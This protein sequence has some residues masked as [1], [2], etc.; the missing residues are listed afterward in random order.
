MNELLVGFGQTI[1]NPVAPKCAGCLNQTI[2]PAAFKGSPQKGRV[3]KESGSVKKEAKEE[4]KLVKNEKSYTPTEE[5]F[6]QPKQK[7]TRKSVK[8]LKY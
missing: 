8:N 3:K 5:D 6:E 2:C 7:R 4:G 1:C